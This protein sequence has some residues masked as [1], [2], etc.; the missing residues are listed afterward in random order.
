MSCCG[1]I[2]TQTRARAQAHVN[3]C[4]RKHTPHSAGVVGHSRRALVRS[5][6]SATFENEN[7]IFQIL[8]L[9]WL[10]FSV[11]G[12]FKWSTPIERSVCA[13]RPT[14][15]KVAVGPWTNTWSLEEDPGT[16]SLWSTAAPVASHLAPAPVPFEDIPI[17]KLPFFK[18]IMVDEHVAVAQ[19]RSG[20]VALWARMN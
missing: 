6:D 12:P 18:F 10:R 1:H 16:A 8:Q 13:F 3:K 7:G 20:G 11:Q 14:E 15:A 5:F 9:D 4:A 19:G 17:T 2:R